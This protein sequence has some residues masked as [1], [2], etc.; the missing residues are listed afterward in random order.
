LV[1]PP[2]ECLKSAEGVLNV[3]LAWHDSLQSAPLDPS[4]RVKDL[5]FDEGAGLFRF[6]TPVQGG[7]YAESLEMASE[8]TR[9]AQTLN[10]VV[11]HRLSEHRDTL[12]RLRR[13]RWAV[14]FEDRNYRMWLV[15]RNPKCAVRV[16]QHSSTTG[17]FASGENQ[18]VI[19][20]RSFD[21]EQAWELTPELAQRVRDEDPDI[22]GGP[23]CADLIGVPLAPYD[24]WL[25]R[26][27]ELYDMENNDLVP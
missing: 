15:G 6:N 5:V 27:C 19:E 1:V 4:K 24:L 13:G 18:Y 12:D 7:A 25:L 10:V 20:F 14:V 23:D 2:F 22:S 16:T 11:P 8:G 17:A 21:W 9:I 3:W 26:D